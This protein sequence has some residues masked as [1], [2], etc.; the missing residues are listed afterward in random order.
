[1]RLP[2]ST[3]DLLWEAAYRHFDEIE[4]AG[5]SVSMFTNWAN[6]VIDQVP[7]RRALAQSAASC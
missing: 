5:Y 1:M 6:D 2:G 4:D 3:D 7:V